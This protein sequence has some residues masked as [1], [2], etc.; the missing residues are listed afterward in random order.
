MVGGLGVQQPLAQRP[1][2]QAQRKLHQ[3]RLVQRR[4]R[5]LFFARLVPLSTAACMATLVLVA[6]SPLPSPY[7]RWL[8]GRYILVCYWKQPWRAERAGCMK[9]VLAWLRA[10]CLLSSAHRQRRPTDQLFKAA[11]SSGRQR[12]G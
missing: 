1:V 6:G 4:G 10:G 2:Q 12:A 8:G 3:Q 7:S 11:R 9:R 5:R